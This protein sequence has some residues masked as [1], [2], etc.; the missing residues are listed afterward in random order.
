MLDEPVGVDEIPDLRRVRLVATDLDGTFLDPDGQV[1]ARAAAAVAAAQAAGIHVIPVTGRP[2]QALWDLADEA[3]LGPLA[4]CANGAAIVDVATRSVLEVS[5]MSG[6]L[7][8]SV[9]EAVRSVAPG[10]PMA[11]DDLDSFSYEPGFFEGPVDW[12]EQL[13]EVADVVDAVRGGCIKLLARARGITPHALITRLDGVLA[14]SAYV[15][16]SGIDWVDLGAPTASKEAG[17]RRVCHRLG[18][19][20]G[21]VAAIGD[22]HN[23]RSLLAWAPIALAPANAVT[24]VLAV[25]HRV[26]PG[27]DAHGVAA[28]LEELAALNS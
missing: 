3:G 12:Q 5:E 4:V 15:T 7:A 1:T 13:A 28:L 17:V 26:L 14:G 24:E 23:D 18:V 27:N 9:V 10:I 16:S 19:D 25:A 11:A 22:N 2:P 6:E 8:V 20:E 21:S